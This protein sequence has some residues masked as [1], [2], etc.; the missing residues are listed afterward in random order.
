ME[1]SLISG[2]VHLSIPALDNTI[3]CESSVPGACDPRK[4]L[5]PFLK[6]PRGTLHGEHC[7]VPTVGILT[8][9]EGSVLK[10][11][12]CEYIETIPAEPSCPVGTRDIGGLCQSTK[13]KGIMERCK[14]GELENNQCVVYIPE[15]H[16]KITGC[17]IGYTEA[18]GSCWK[19]VEMDCTPRADAGM[20]EASV[21]AETCLRH[22]FNDS[23]NNNT[24]PDAEIGVN[25]R[26]R[27]LSILNDAYSITFADGI[28]MINN[29]KIGS[30]QTYQ[31][32]FNE[33]STGLGDIAA[34]LSTV[35]ERLSYNISNN[36]FSTYFQKNK[37]SLA[38]KELI[39][40]YCDLRNKVMQNSIS[41]EPFDT[42][43]L[44]LINNYSIDYSVTSEQNWTNAIEKSKL[45]SGA[46]GQ[47]YLCEHVLDDIVLGYYAI[48]K[49]PVGN[50]KKMLAK[51][52]KE[53]KM[54]ESL[55]HHNIVSYKH[56]WL[57][58]HKGTALPP[59][60][61]PWLFV[62][63][64]YCAGGSLEELITL[65]YIQNE[66]I[67]SENQVW[68][69]FFDIIFGLQHLH[70]HYIVHRDLKPSNILLKLQSEVHTDN[71]EIPQVYA[72]LADFGTAD[73]VSSSRT[74][75]GYTGTKEDICIIGVAGQVGTAVASALALRN[76]P[77]KI[78]GVDIKEELAMGRLLD[79]D[80][81]TGINNLPYNHISYTTF[82]KVKNCDII[83]I[84]SGVPQKPGQTR[85][86]LIDINLKIMKSICKSIKPLKPTTK[87]I[88]ISNPVDILTYFLQKEI[89]LPHNQVF[90]SG[91]FLDTSRLK[92]QL[93]Y[94][95]NIPLDKVNIYVIGEHGD[96]QFVVWS[97]ATENG[98]S[99]I[100]K[101]K[102]TRDNQLKI[103]EITRKR[104]YD[105]INF[106]GATC[107]GI[108][109]H[110]SEIIFQM[111]S[112]ANYI[113]PLSHYHEK[114]DL[115]MSTPCEFNNDGIGKTLDLSLNDEEKQKFDEC[116]E[117][118]K[119]IIKEHNK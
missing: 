78:F 114:L 36:I 98:K 91:T 15:S 110:I 46:Y 87:V 55:N 54:R 109:A 102:I 76:Y 95:Y 115:Y 100:E 101:Y 14:A 105:I 77:G 108:G 44:G 27:Y 86:E 62:L 111:Q 59:V 29:C 18:R 12:Q 24:L 16:H 106:V 23:N 8:C 88:V 20:V 103:E 112:N 31:I 60:Y 4:A 74:G 56:S 13:I 80:D 83:I 70:H 49:I 50:D 7:V 37:F 6:C 64:E 57:E 113:L 69:L 65:V 67:L 28:G 96:D 11:F 47:V 25:Q 81:A 33:V 116:V 75:D 72:C 82:D 38:L 119:K 21:H 66:S 79:I 99:I 92:K 58:F 118:L 42:S 107:F 94:S 1:L 48:K 89:G 32:N 53:V 68:V 34:L 5:K 30:N 9:D 3:V 51:M 90:G 26:L 97:N 71:V 84:S 39:G 19:S 35:S 61:V 22:R 63:M 93:N 40:V 17:P 10:D 52:L 45:G 85:T 73:Y 41:K 2:Q 104:A 117:K 43:T